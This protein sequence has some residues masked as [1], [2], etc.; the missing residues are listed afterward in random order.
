MEVMNPAV[1][2]EFEAIRRNRI[3]EEIARQIEKMITEKMKAG[4]RLPP[5]RQLADMFGV[6]RSSIRDAIRTL[7]MSGMVEARQGLG[8]VVREH[9]ADA[10]VNPLTQV[11]VQK[12]KL[13]GELL[14]VRKMIEPPLAARAAVHATSDEVAEME[15]ILRRQEEKMRRRRT[16]DRRGQR[17][18]LRDCAG[19]RQ[20]RGAEGAGRADGL[21][22][23]DARAV[24]AGGR[25]AGEFHGR[26]PGDPGRDQA[27]GPGRRGS[28]PCAGTSSQWRRSYSRSFDRA[29]DA[30]GRLF[31]V[32]IVY[33]G[34]FQK[35]LANN[36]SRGIVLAAHLDGKPGISF[37]R[38]GDSPERNGIPAKNFAI[39]ATDEQTLEEGMAKYEPK[40]VDVTICVDDTLCKGVESWAWYGLQPIN[41][42][43][44]PGG[45]LIVTS[46][47]PP[48][49][50]IGMAHRKEHAVQPG[51]VKGT[52]SFSGLWVYKDDHTDVRILG[53]IAKVLPDL[54]SLDAIKKTI[55]SEWKDPVKV[56]SAEKSYNRVT[57]VAVKPGQG[58]PETPYKFELPKWHEMGEG[59]AI[60]VH[61]RG[62]AD[63]RPD[64]A[65]DGRHTARTAIPTFKK[66]STR[67][68]RPVV[69]FETC[70]KCTLCWLQC[71]DTCFD[72]T[73]EGLYDANMEACC[74]CGVC[75][76]VCPVDK[77]VTMV[78]ETEFKDNGSQWE[79]WRKDATGYLTWL[80]EKIETRPERS[81]GFRYTRPVPGTSRRNAADRP[82]RIRR[83]ER[84]SHGDNSALR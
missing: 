64:D 41:K 79:T 83:E 14:D 55:Q 39:V 45:T 37:G 70:I 75:E 65:R 9:S 84:R 56:A 49:T 22:A 29:E 74:G 31:A 32:E 25:E 38:Y 59:V 57:K 1:K 2:P 30:M 35:T 3:Y 24:A 36:I 19:S 7:E 40:E 81:H 52:P 28:W 11:L 47:E 66:F 5:E 73:P 68:M 12:R 8:T 67:T 17:V 20:Q 78:D 53:A 16:G 50:L 44:K 4:D 48:E 33:R 69:N 63:G 58:N 82:R 80:N 62:Q 18:S 15:D 61:S 23:R 13:V 21:A 60:P 51:I 42:L 34:I 43:T 77:C 27:P 46:M 72:V 6:S 54:F 76:A 71:P 10:V 26:P